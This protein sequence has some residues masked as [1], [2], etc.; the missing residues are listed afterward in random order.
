MTIHVQSGDALTAA[1][2]YEIWR[3]RDVV[4]AVEQQADEIDADGLDLLPTCTH[5]WLA[6]DAGITSYLR[7]FTTDTGVRKIGRVATRRDARGQGLAGRLVQEVLDRWGDG[8]IRLGAQAYLH[9]WYAGFGFSRD[10]ENFWEAGIEHVP[11]V[12]PGSDVPT[13]DVR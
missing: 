5:M 6:D 12:R 4:F 3:V 8:E 2:V 7:T 11:M 10:G 13:A 9:D 1:E